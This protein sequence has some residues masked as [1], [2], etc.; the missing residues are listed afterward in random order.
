MICALSWPIGPTGGAGQAAGTILVSLAR[1]MGPD[2]VDSTAG[3]VD[4]ASGDQLIRS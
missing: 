4:L 2:H 3:Y 1:T